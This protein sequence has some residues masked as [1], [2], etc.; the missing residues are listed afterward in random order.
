MKQ[1]R[2]TSILF[3]LFLLVPFHLASYN[4]SSQIVMSP[5]YFDLHEQFRA[6]RIGNILWVEPIQPLTENDCN[7]SGI[8]KKV[9]DTKRLI[10]LKYAPF[11]DI[12]T[13]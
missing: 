3:F 11:Q 10:D 5:E 6:I 1:K 7:I 13:F 8:S 12:Y 2:I 9:K 4:L